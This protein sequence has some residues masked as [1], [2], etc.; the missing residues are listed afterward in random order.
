M[1][2]NGIASSPQRLMPN[3][4]DPSAV[5]AEILIRFI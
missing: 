4:C 2:L 5:C 3:D 1:R